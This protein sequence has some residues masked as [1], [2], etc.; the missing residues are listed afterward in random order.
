MSKDLIDSGTSTIQTESIYLPLN[1][2][3]TAS[4]KRAM[5]QEFTTGTSV[6]QRKLEV[7]T[8]ICGAYVD[9]PVTF[10]GCV[11]VGERKIFDAAKQVAWAVNECSKEGWVTGGMKDMK[12]S[13]IRLVSEPHELEKFVIISYVSMTF[14]GYTEMKKRD[15]KAEFALGELPKLVEK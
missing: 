7:I 6:R 8:S 13:L 3:F 9:D 2:L 10:F 12:L 15:F 5:R 4:S 1:H 14:Y 11:A